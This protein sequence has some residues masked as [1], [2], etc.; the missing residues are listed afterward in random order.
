MR[1][2]VTRAGRNDASTPEPPV[3][4]TMRIDLHCHTE[5]SRDSTIPLSQRPARCW[6]RAIRVQA[7]TDHNEI[8]GALELRERVDAEGSDP[9]ILI[10]EEITTSEGEIVGLFLTERIEAG[11]SPEETVARIKAQGGPAL[12]PHGFDPWN[13][14]TLHPEA[15]ER[16][17]SAVDIVE[18]FNARVSRHRW[19]QAAAEWARARGLPISAGSDAH[20]LADIGSAWVEVPMQPIRGPKD[21][22][23]ALRQGTPTGEWQHP[24]LT[25]IERML[26]RHR[27]RYRA[28]RRGASGWRRRRHRPS[29]AKHLRVWIVAAQVGTGDRGIARGVAVRAGMGAGVVGANIGGSIAAAARARRLR[30]KIQGQI[31]AQS[32]D[33]VWIH[34]VCLMHIR[35]GIHQ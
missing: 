10:G 11:L 26:E 15:R 12:L 4:E 3:V 6:Q 5:V 22:L 28:R 9:V 29:R 33:H 7:I 24:L 13:Y 1:R 32:G 35:E 31:R 8:R 17:A 27:H 16:I 23:R 20:T 18:A 25:L 14:S 21:L 34:A 19:N 2:E 30:L